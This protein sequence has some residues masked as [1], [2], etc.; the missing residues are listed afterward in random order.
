MKN[1]KLRMKFLRKNEK[2]KIKNEKLRRKFLRKNEKL[3]IKNEKLRRKFLR[4][5]LKIYILKNFVEILSLIFN[6]SFYIL[7]FQLAT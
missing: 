4:E 1:E 3:K 2:L 5:F 7:H 6:S